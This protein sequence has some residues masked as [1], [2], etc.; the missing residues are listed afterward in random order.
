[1]GKVSESPGDDRVLTHT[2]KSCP[3]TKRAAEYS[4]TSAG[5]K[6]APLQVK[7]VNRPRSPPATDHWQ[8]TTALPHDFHLRPVVVEVAAAIEAHDVRPRLRRCDA[9]PFF[10]TGC[11][12][13]GRRRREWQ[14]RMTVTAASGKQLQQAVPHCGTQ[15]LRLRAVTG[16]VCFQSSALSRQF[17]ASAFF[18]QL[19]ADR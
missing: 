19:L 7:D 8:L 1:M 15:V 17:S 4:V 2:L 12:P 16:A 5:D 14:R 3:V 6:P 11:F 13:G 18:L 9:V 10:V